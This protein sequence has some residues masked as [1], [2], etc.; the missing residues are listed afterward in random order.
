MSD[1][2]IAA[3]LREHPRMMGVLF[4]LTV[5]LTQVGSVAA[6]ANGSTIS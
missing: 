4:T 3:Y 5:L 1:T 6:T 2:D